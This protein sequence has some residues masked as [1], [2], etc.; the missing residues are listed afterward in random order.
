MRGK[1]EPVVRRGLLLAILIGALVFVSSAFAADQIVGCKQSHFN[2]DD[3][4]VFPGQPG[5]SHRH[6]YAGAR[7]NDAFSTVQSMKASGTTCDDTGDTAGYWAPTF[8]A[9]YPI[10]PSKGALFYYT[11]NGTQFPE[12]LKMVVRWSTP[13]NRVRFKCGPG[14]ATETRTVPASCGSGMLV[15][16]VDFPQWWDGRL[17]SPDHLSHM[18]YSRTATHTTRLPH[19]KV[20]WRLAVP[21]GAPI[22]SNLSS[23]DYTTFHLDFLS[24]GAI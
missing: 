2:N 5:A 8:N 19:L 20:Y 9:G 16:V 11:F 24:T 21:A 1:T 15:P 23:G 13:G 3:Q 22:D 12:G 17:D 4:I 10:H 7:S 14:S 18:S 6:Q